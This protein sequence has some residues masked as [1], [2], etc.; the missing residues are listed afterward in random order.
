M[1]F[2]LEGIAL[3]GGER[4]NPRRACFLAIGRRSIRTKTRLYGNLNQSLEE[5]TSTS[6]P[7]SGQQG[8][9]GNMP[10]SLIFDS[11]LP[12]FV[13]GLPAGAEA[14]IHL[15]M[16]NLDG[17]MSEVSTFDGLIDELR[18]SNVENPERKMPIK[19]RLR[20]DEHTVA[21]WH[22]DEG[23]RELRCIGPRPYPNRRG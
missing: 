1:R 17:V 10:S 14:F 7:C 16:K 6:P 15:G 23:P 2:L 22:F 20:P 21:L 8:Y 3:W 4:G 13:G 18:I 5:S 19:K 9:F 12:L 11:D